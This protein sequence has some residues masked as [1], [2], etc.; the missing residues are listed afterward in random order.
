MRIVLLGA[1]GAGKGT[2]AARINKKYGIAHISTGDILRS[3][4]KEQTPL[5][6][7]AKG[8]MDKGEL[9]PDDLVVKLVEDRLGKGDLD[10]G[11]MLDG[12]PRTVDQAEKLDTILKK[13]NCELNAVIN[14]DVDKSL[15]VERITGRR[16]CKNCQASY[17]ISYQ[18]PKE[19]GICDSCGSEL[20]QRKD[21]T[22][23]TVE[24]RLE[25]YEKQTEPLIDFYGTKGIRK[26]IDGS[27]NFDDVFAQ[28]EK[29][30][31]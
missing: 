13:L 1:P 28:I 12:F 3:N 26:D 23:E 21:D 10:D 6:L 7:E 20:I 18:K 4:V 5:G 25:V 9:V 29:V 2:Q 30:L 15:L 19:E 31:V 17:H 11:F 27:K 16:L 24:N 14:I 8:Y 22:K